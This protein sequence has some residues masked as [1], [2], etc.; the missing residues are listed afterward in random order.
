[1]MPANVHPITKQDIDIYIQPISNGRY[2]VRRRINNLPNV[3]YIVNSNIAMFVDPS[4]PLYDPLRAVTVLK[5]MFPDKLQVEELQL[6]ND[7]DETVAPLP[8]IQSSKQP[9]YEKI[10]MKKWCQRSTENIT[11]G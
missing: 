4:S 9:I 8:K 6:K 1:M 10:N 2:N 3:D 7:N 11:I 5:D